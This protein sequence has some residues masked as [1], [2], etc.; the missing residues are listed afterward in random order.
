MDAFVR[1]A[2]LV[3]FLPLLGALVAA[4]GGK[5]LKERSHLPVIAGIGL[6]FLVSLVLLFSI[7]RTTAKP[8]PIE[9]LTVSNLVV[10]IQFQVDGLTTMMLAMVTFV[11]TLVAVYS[12]GYMAGDPAYPRFFALVGLFVF[13]MTGL[14]L[15]ANYLLTYVFWEGVGVCSYLLVGFW[16]SKPEASLAA[17]K[18]FLVNRVGD[19]GFAIAIFWMWVVSPGHDLNYA[20]FLAPENLTKLL[21]TGALVGIALLLFWAATAKSAQVPLYVWLPDAMEGP[22][23]VSALIHAATMVTAGVYLIARSSPLLILVPG[24]QLTVSVIGCVTALLAA[25]IAV[26]QTDLKRV[27]AYST[28]SQLGYMFMGLG[29]GVQG[30]GEIAIIAGM[31]HLFTHAFFK[32]LLF[33]A[34]GSVMHSMGGVIDMREFGGL[35]QRMPVTHL[36]FASGALALCGIPIFAG[37]FS[38]DEI[39]SSLTLAAR[40]SNSSGG[41][42]WG[43]VYYAIYTVATLTAFLTAFYTGRAYF[44]TFW[45]PE[46]LPDLSKVDAHH[47]SSEHEL[48]A[49]SHR[50][51]H[52]SHFGHESPPVMT[53]PLI[54]LAVCALL[55]GLIFGPTG[56][57][58]HHLAQTPELHAL[59]TEGL[60]G[61]VKAVE[62]S[63]DWV[64]MLVGTLAAALGLGLSYFFYF[65]PSP[66][67]ARLENQ[68]RPLYQASLHKFLVDELYNKVIV[69]PTRFLGLAANFLDNFLVSGLVQGVA[70]LPRV[71]GRYILGPRQN[72]LIQYYAAITALSVG[73]LLLFLF[74]AVAG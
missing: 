18:A 14:V 63:T 50:S 61:S 15:S 35:R 23:P 2:W 48:S 69:W 13:S 44:L 53:Y 20:T 68:F 58:E 65:K 59:E 27:M 62:H 66:W 67:P 34:S 21:P 9:W 1:N 47:G 11:A 31:F 40:A 32:A 17:K 16:H 70:S 71:V 8:A 28:V 38:K 7:G 6:A 5:W 55:V 22:T 33:L 12:S 51:G 64:T 73:M 10:P 74:F 36:T 60:A 24:V 25:A 42:G 19:V 26:T 45:G 52:D 54:I 29:A 41:E 3:P 46:K 57:F 30:V 43:W 37:F 49:D 56:L 4:I 39:L 72:G